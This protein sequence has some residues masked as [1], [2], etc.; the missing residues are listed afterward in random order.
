MTF[1][2]LPFRMETDKKIVN[3]EFGAYQFCVEVKKL[4]SCHL[5]P[6]KG[7]RRI[8][9]GD[10]ELYYTPNLDFESDDEEVVIEFLNYAKRNVIG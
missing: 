1:D 3:C 8:Y 5:Y 10:K 9:M 6:K 4:K 2:L 7:D